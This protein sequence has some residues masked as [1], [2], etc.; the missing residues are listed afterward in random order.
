MERFDT[1][2][3]MVF[4][5]GSRAYK[6]KRAVKFPYMDFS[7]LAKRKWACE[8]EITF[9]RRTAPSLYLH[10]LAINRAGDAGDS[11][12]AGLD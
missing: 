2:G 9:N 1:H 8:R 5:A 11:G 6:V 7:T 12:E 4:L 3:A 10:T